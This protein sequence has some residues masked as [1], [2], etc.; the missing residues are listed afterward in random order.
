MGKRCGGGGVRCGRD[1]LREGCA[2][3]R[4]EGLQMAHTVCCF[5]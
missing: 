1:V 3:G 5:V 4:V 2:E